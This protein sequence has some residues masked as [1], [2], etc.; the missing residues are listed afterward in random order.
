MSKETFT[1]G[2]GTDQ[3]ISKAPGPT[4]STAQSARRATS[5][6]A[7]N[8]GGSSRAEVRSNRTRTAQR[9]RRARQV[10]ATR[11]RRRTML[12]FA[13]IPLVLVVVIIAVLLITS[14]APSTVGLVNANDLNPA[15]SQLSVGTKA[16]DFTLKTVDGKS[17]SL[18]SFKGKPVLLE[19]FAVWCPVCQAEST[20]LNQID[21]A[22][23]P[24]GL[25]TIAVLANPYGKNYETSGRNDLTLVTKSDI[26]WYISNFKVKH[27]T[28][29]DPTF[30]TVNTY[31]ASSYPG[32][33]ILD[34]N[35]T[36]RY[37]NSGEQPYSSLASV[38]TTLLK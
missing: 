34:K 16:P 11:A 7:A 35:G 25:Q 12:L 3:P 20:T 29:I 28:L 6:P 15:G 36:I 17:Y 31:G 32:L 18:S 24:K 21:A 26:N 37:A 27:L 5:R 9:S 33:Y 8:A 23:G 10:T 38:I 30:K 13:G 4:G 19:F 1:P 14:N 22:F 2:S